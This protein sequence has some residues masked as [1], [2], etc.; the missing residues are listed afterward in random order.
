MNKTRFWLSFRLEIPFCFE[1]WNFREG[2]LHKVGNAEEKEKGLEC[3][4]RFPWSFHR[5]CACFSAVLGESSMC[6]G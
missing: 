4:R 5:T 1:A 2:Q 3:K 6:G